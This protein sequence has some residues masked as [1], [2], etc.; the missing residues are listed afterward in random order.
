MRLEI[1]YYASSER[2][3]QW[4][5]VL[6]ALFFVIAVLRVSSCFGVVFVFVSRVRQPLVPVCL[7]FVGAIGQRVS[8]AR[9][10]TSDV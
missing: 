8:P 4:R 5:V 1:L 10:L 9:H 2:R 6:C 7:L 3:Y